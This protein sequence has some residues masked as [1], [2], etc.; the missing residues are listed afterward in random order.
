MVASHQEGIIKKDV[1]TLRMAKMVINPMTIMRRWV[2]V[3]ER[4]NE[5]NVRQSFPVSFPQM[6]TLHICAQN[7]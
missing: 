1:I 2:I 5:K 3:V 7:L 4:E 6:I